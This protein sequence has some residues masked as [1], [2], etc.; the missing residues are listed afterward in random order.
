MWV[1]DTKE[2]I[3]T[4]HLG[5]SDKLDVKSV[6]INPKT[7]EII[8]V[9]AEEQW[10]AHHVRFLNSTKKSLHLPEIKLYKARW[11]VQ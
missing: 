11:N 9:Q 8:Y 3:F 5:L 6:S 4:K 10:W 1:F 2:E 7:N